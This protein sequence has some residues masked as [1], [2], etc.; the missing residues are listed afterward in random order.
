MS[1]IDILCQLLTFDENLKIVI[2]MQYRT[3]GETGLKV[4]ILGMGCMRLPV[5]IVKRKAVVM[6]E[7]A[8]RVIRKAIDSGINYVDSAYRYHGSQSE[9]ILGKALKDGYR[10][11]VFIETKLYTPGLKTADDFDRL[12]DEQ[13]KKLDVNYIDV[14]LVHG[15]N[16]KRYQN[17][18]SKFNIIEKLQKAKEDGK[19][20]HIG[21]SSH[22]EP[23]N[24]IKII[25]TGFFEVMLVQYNLLDQ[26]NEEIIN[27]AAKNGLGVVLMG[28]NGGGRLGISP[29]KD[30]EHLLSP[31]RTNFI[32]LALKFVWNN[33][34]V[35]VA[36]SGMSNES[37][38][39]ENVKFANIKENK[40][41]NSDLERIEKINSCYKKLADIN[42]TQ[43]G[44]CMDDC[45]E[46]INIKY[47]LQQLIHS[48]TDAGH[49]EYAKN[50]YK[51]IGRDKK[52]PGKNAEA[53]ITCGNCEDACPQE[54]AIIEK[55]QEAHKLLSG[56][57]SYN[58]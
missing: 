57:D 48:V 19:I 35:S 16:W 40:L 21:F 44:Y 18:I 52:I 49:W 27:H 23:E 42:C 3:L 32:D 33:P 6:E 55:L 25:D 12:L 15:L 56:L 8:I 2:V 30:I 54:I 51:K 28:P 39:E 7:E 38:V 20:K 50:N 14:Y 43:C 53:C 22:D 41:T 47:I 4:S 37:M 36:L 9:I 13:L 31:N 24:I 34:N 26:E 46:N 10:E 5:T 1:I 17:V 29:P 11:K 45:P 58:I